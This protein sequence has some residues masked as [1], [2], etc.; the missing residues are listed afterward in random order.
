MINTFDITISGYLK[1]FVRRPD[2]RLEY[3]TYDGYHEFWQFYKNY[4]T[5]TLNLVN[6]E[7]FKQLKFPIIDKVIFK[8]KPMSMFKKLITENIY[9]IKYT[10]TSFKDVTYVKMRSGTTYLVDESVECLKNALDSC[11]W[12]DAFLKAI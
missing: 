12:S 2:G 9:D 10:V 6:I 7:S 1:S 8:E 5:M 11:I 3:F 4:E